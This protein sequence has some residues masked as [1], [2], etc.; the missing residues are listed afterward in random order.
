MVPSSFSERFIRTFQRFL[1]SP[2]AIAVL[3]TGLTFILALVLTV[4]KEESHVIELVIYWKNGFFGFLTFAMQ[5]MLILVLG[6]A[7][8]LSKPVDALLEKLTKHCNST[9]KGAFIVTLIS[10]CIALFNWG[11][12]LIAGS[13]FARKVAEHCSRKKIAINYP[14]IGAAGYSGMMVWHGGLSGSAPL[15]VGELNH[16]F[17]DLVGQI[18]FSQTIFSGMNLVCI[19]LL[20]LVLPTAMYWMGKKVRPTEMN[21]I[22]TKNIPNSLDQTITGAERID[23]STFGGSILGLCILFAAFYQVIWM[24]ISSDT[25]FD[26]SFGFM[27]PNFI[28]LVLFGLC[29]LFHRS[30]IR[31]NQAVLQAIGGSAGIMI[32]F[33]FYAGIMG[34]MQSSGLV[35]LFSDFFVTISTEQS[36]PIFTFISAGF[37]N[38]FVPSGGGQW[39]VQGPIIIEASQQL[40]VP[41]QKAIMA[42]CYG[43]QVTNMLQPF[44]ALPLLGITQLKAKEILP[45]TLY[46]FALG[47]LIYCLVLLIF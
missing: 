17:Y 11:L 22:Y 40:N 23:Y 10:I 19:L 33:P 35:T 12:G 25:P 26:W 3:L 46:L 20:L 6:H 38:I 4:P 9:A 45:Y 14:L 42:L 16:E 1:P 24:P 34:I 18:P 41:I 37:V 21:Q 27:N 28:I 47:C 29:L 2:F 44:W 31:F 43:D 5:M 8:A 13:I 15:K 30:F 39:L 36:F 32:Q 7:L